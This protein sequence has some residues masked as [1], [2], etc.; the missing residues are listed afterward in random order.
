MDKAFLQL[1]LASGVL[2]LISVFA[3]KTSTRYGI[4]ILLIFI[5][6]GMLSGVEGPGGIHFDRPVLTHILGTISLM[7]ILFSGGL[8]TQ[9]QTVSP[10][11]KE[12]TLLAFFGVIISTLV[13]ACIIHFALG[14]DWVSSAL[15]S[16]TCSSTDASA[17]FG[18]LKTQKL[19]LRSRIQSLLELESG[20]ND[21]TAVFLTLSLIQ[22]ILRPENFTWNEVLM[23]FFIQMSLGGLAGW[24]LGKGMVHLINW[25]DLEFE[26]LYPVLTIA[27]VICIY[28]L[29]EFC[30]GNGFLSVY[31]AGLAM[32]DEK[33]FNKKT[34]TVF[35][36]GL[37][38]LMQVIMFLM[39]G[40]LVI[41]SAIGPIMGTGVFLSLCLL[42]VARP[43]SVYF[44][45]VRFKYS[46]NEMMFVSWGGLRGAIPIILATYLL[47][48]KVPGSKT[49][50]NLIFFI[51]I[52]L[53]LIQGT[54]LGHLAKWLK[55]QEPFSPRR[56][57]PFKSRHH[58]KDFVEF[59]VR[60]GSPL[61]GKNILELNF[62]MQVL[63]VLIHRGEEDFMPDG[64][65]DIE[66]YD[67]L[68]CL[69]DT[70][71]IPELEKIIQCR[72]EDF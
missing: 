48:N 55:V 63:V 44:C 70:D 7:F 65:T 5:L 9:L 72:R 38:W 31:I 8:S 53:M 50:F 2:L 11:W 17:V 39:L 27:G 42:F 15:L 22:I 52:L 62:P 35:H 64:N 47:V 6:V 33:Y 40:L 29:T 67:R 32:S 41:P 18:I 58:G 30:G 34:L 49:M 16:A 66:L 13:M 51:V 10:V 71:A 1:M 19:Q 12:G 4:P 45:L 54:S 69:V 60:E 57:L 21:P 36:D 23:N 68:V 61:L 46:L 14:W 37:A 3:S 43:L 28:S 20:S 59:E 56:R 24:F 25:L 26:G